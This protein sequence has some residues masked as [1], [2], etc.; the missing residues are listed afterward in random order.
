MIVGAL[1][2]AAGAAV[3][4]IVADEPSWFLIT[5][6]LAVGFGVAALVEPIRLVHRKR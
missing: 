4:P 2:I 5:G 3:A 1:A 6:P